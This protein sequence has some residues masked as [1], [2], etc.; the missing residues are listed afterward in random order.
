[1]I[2]D[3]ERLADKMVGQH[4]VR[5][6]DCKVGK[7]IRRLS[8]DELPRFFNVRHR[9]SGAMVPPRWLEMPLGRSE[10]LPSCATGS[11]H[12]GIRRSDG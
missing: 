10:K 12:G 1:M 11:T 5:P 6:V 8:I 9:E 4:N 2:E 3:P 7:V